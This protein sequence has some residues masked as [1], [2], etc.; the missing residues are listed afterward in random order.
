MQ[1]ARLAQ[2]LARIFGVSGNPGGGMSR[3][4]R[5]GADGSSGCLGA[6]VRE[7][8]TAAPGVSALTGTIANRNLMIWNRRAINKLVWTYFKLI[9]C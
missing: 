9:G 4:S 1:E 3:L 6:E 2:N 5:W 7:I 8:L